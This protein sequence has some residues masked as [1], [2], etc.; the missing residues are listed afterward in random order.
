[1]PKRYKIEKITC[2]DYDDM[3]ET[4]NQMYSKDY[5]LIGYRLY[6][7]SELYQKAV[8]KLYQRRKGVKKDGKGTR[9]G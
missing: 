3:I 1:M 8:L 2:V 4:Y 7:S 9:T 5:Q 6:K